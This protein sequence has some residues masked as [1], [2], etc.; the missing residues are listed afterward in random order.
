MFKNCCG[1]PS[2]KGER[3]D[4]IEENYVEKNEK[5]EKETTITFEMGGKLASATSENVIAQTEVK[6]PENDENSDQVTK[7]VE[8]SQ[9]SNRK[10]SGPKKAKPRLS[11]STEVKI[12]PT[13]FPEDLED[14]R[15]EEY[16]E[17]E[18]REKDKKGK[19]GSKE[20]EGEKGKNE[21]V[22][23][24]VGDNKDDDEDDDE[25]DENEPESLSLSVKNI[26]GKIIRRSVSEES[27]RKPSPEEVETTRTVSPLSDEV[28]VAG[29]KS[30]LELPLNNLGVKIEN[31]PSAMSLNIPGKKPLIN[32]QKRVSMPAVLPKWLSEEE[33]TGGSQ[34]PPATPVSQNNL[35][36]I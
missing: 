25:D 32:A 28:F 15:F 36:I 7:I 19:E 33:E 26:D 12:I 27:C 16:S 3:K 14:V 29:E 34:E 35:W 20:G 22:V 17:L 9:S 31:M 8:S 23:V 30:H 24:V 13:N 5:E 6:K 1:C 10:M 21:N 2:K 4:S 11:I 18:E